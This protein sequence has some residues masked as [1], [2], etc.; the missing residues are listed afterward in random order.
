MTNV[1]ERGAQCQY[2]AAAIAVVCPS[3]DHRKPFSLQEQDLLSGAGS[4]P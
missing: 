1:R 4:P 3:N 2:L